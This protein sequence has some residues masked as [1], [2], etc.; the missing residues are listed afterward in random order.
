MIKNMV[1]NSGESILKTWQ[2]PCISFG[3]ESRIRALLNVG[4][5]P[6]LKIRDEQE[7]AA[8]GGRS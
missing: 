4:S 5:T 7:S 8:V 3:F 1:G 2:M 6:P